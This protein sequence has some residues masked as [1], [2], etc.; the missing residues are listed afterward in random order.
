[1]YVRFV[2]A[3]KAG[4]VTAIFSFRA[5]FYNPETKCIPRF[6]WNNNWAKYSGFLLFDNVLLQ[7]NIDVAQSWTNKNMNYYT[8]VIV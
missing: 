5:K 4:G 6:I 7:W 8:P 3:M 2:L 1:M